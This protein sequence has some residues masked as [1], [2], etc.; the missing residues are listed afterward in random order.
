M[1]AI[2]RLIIQEISLILVGVNSMLSVMEKIKG[3]YSRS[4][5]VEELD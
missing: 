2:L 4:I 3:T 1:G 5:N